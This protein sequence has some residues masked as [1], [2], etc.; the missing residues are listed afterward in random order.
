MAQDSQN[1]SRKMQF[2]TV[3]AGLSATSGLSLPVST[4]RSTT[5]YGRHLPQS[6]NVAPEDRTPYLSRPTGSPTTRGHSAAS[7]L[8]A[9]VDRHV[10][11]FGR[12]LHPDPATVAVER[13]AG[14]M[15]A[16][17]LGTD[18]QPRDKKGM[19][20]KQQIAAIATPGGLSGD[21]SPG[22]LGRMA[23]KPDAAI[24]ASGLVEERLT[25][26]EGMMKGSEVRPPRAPGV[27][28]H[29]L[30]EA[31]SNITP[32]IKEKMGL[33]TVSKGKVETVEG[34]ERL[35]PKGK[36]TTMTNA[37]HTK[38]AEKQIAKRKQA[39]GGY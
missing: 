6:V 17:G 39:E 7:A 29:S 4:L 11:M 19:E 12:V 26:T 36:K 28:K 16:V 1:N 38:R 24:T 23:G 27:A 14:R 10:A 3:D 13:R 20:A 18:V 30:G 25:A 31:P 33:V 35:V 37:E 32:K 21:R 15:Q 2:P 34:K 9:E 22:A 8:A 5:E